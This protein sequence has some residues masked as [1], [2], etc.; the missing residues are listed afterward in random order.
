MRLGG[1][2]TFVHQLFPPVARST[3]KA[4]RTSDAGEAE[5]GRKGRKLCRPTYRHRFFLQCTYVVI[6]VVSFLSSFFSLFPPGN[7]CCNVPRIVYAPLRLPA[8]NDSRKLAVTSEGEGN[9]AP[10]VVPRHSQ[11]RRTME[12]FNRIRPSG[13][14]T[15]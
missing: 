7:A 5:L 14:L 10:R 4:K 6:V 8:D 13:H 15:N 9:R 11:K 2:S 12:K 1:A 3:N